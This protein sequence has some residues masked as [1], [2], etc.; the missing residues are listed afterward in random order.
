MCCDVAILNF[1][2]QELFL[3]FLIRICTSVYAF[4]YYWQEIN[5]HHKFGQKL[6]SEC[7]TQC[8]VITMVCL[9]TESINRSANANYEHQNSV[10]GHQNLK[11]QHHN[12]RDE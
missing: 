10:L 3:M 5:Y 9:G 1:D 8:Y 4:C 7:H 11:L 12:A 2:I 6:C